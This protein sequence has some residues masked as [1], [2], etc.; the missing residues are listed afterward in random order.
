MFGWLPGSQIQAKQLSCLHRI[1]ILLFCFL[2]YLWYDPCRPTSTCSWRWPYRIPVRTLDSTVHCVS[3]L[4]SINT[5][6]YASQVSLVDRSSCNS[7][8]G[9]VYFIIVVRGIT[10][11]KPEALLP[12]LLFSFVRYHIMSIKKMIQIYVFIYYFNC[13]LIPYIYW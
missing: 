10:G 2:S 7:H 12:L 13:Y 9:W 4:T 3:S 6:M 11:M 5:V 8:W 1:H